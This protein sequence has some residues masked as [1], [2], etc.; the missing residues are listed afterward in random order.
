MFADAFLTYYA[1]FHLGELLCDRYRGYYLA[2]RGYKI[3]LQV[4]KM[5]SLVKY[6]STL[7]GKFR[8]SKRPCNVQFMI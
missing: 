7:K 5:S 6:F 1:P 8:I 4:L 3:S 2:A